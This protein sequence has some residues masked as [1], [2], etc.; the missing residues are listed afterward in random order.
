MSER[1]LALAMKSVRLTEE[2][3]ALPPGIAM[4]AV[5]TLPTLDPAIQRYLAVLCRTVSAHDAP[6]GIQHNPVQPPTAQPDRRRS[7]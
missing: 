4:P 6:P 2:Q 5:E 3:E 1:S 7:V